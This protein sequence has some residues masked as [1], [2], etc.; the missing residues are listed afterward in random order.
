M[1]HLFLTFFVCASAVSLSA[2][3]VVV[4]KPGEAPTTIT[5]PNGC[6]VTTTVPAPPVVEPPPP[7][8]CTWTVT[9]TALSF[10]AAGAEQPVIVAANRE[11]CSWGT[12]GSTA[13]LTLDP[14][15]GSVRVTALPNT[16]AVRSATITIAGHA[17]PVTQ[18]A[19]VVVPPPPPPPTGVRTL[20]RMDCSVSFPNCNMG[21]WGANPFHTFTR[22]GNGFRLDLVGG[23]I[24]TQF[25]GGVGGNLASNSADAVYVQMHITVHSPFNPTGVGDTWTDKAFMLNDATGNTGERAIG[26]LR[27][28]AN[29]MV[30]RVQKNIN[31]PGFMSEVALPTDRTVAVQFEV[32]RGAQ[33]R[34]AIWL[35]NPTFAS[36]TS[37]SPTF[38]WTVSTW[39]NVRVGFYHN[40]ALAVSGRVA[41]TVTDFKV[42]DAFD[43]SFR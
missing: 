29:G 15:S 9:P 18:A 41:F 26:E 30:L 38:A 21:Y 13:W 35:D 32:R 14:A 24:Q 4:T 34:T 43:P 42:T 28:G 16:G 17:I 33:G 27:P 6:T 37:V 10:V 3:S 5:C 1:R 8:A 31:G 39:R 22:A 11:G 25:Y 19:A 36:P 2:Q 23:T 40:A 7:P 12:S 20:A